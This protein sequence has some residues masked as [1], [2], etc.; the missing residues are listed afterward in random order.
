VREAA[1]RVRAGLSALSY[2]TTSEAVAKM[3]DEITAAIAD[4]VKE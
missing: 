3:A 2:L 1:N 4:L